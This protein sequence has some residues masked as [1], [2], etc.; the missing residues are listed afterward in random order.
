MQLGCQVVVVGNNGYDVAMRWD[1]TDNES[2][3][4]IQQIHILFSKD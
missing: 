4:R 1:A 3:F 2:N